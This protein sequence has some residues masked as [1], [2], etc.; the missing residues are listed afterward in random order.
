LKTDEIVIVDG[1]RTAIGNFGGALRGIPVT[2][3]GSKVISEL[4]KRNGLRPVPPKEN[5][6]FQPK[7][8]NQGITELEKK[9]Y[10]WDVAQKEIAI[11]EVI[12]GN[13]LQAGQGQNQEGQQ[14]SGGHGGDPRGEVVREDVRGAPPGRI[15]GRV[16]ERRGG[17]PHR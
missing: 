12:M 6:K 11:D 14:G 4:L 17:H 2:Q 10:I 15:R 5:A 9:F 8:L 13:V 3:L 7:L 1:V 16:L